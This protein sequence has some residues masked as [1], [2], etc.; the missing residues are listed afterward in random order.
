MTYDIQ[1]QFFLLQFWS[2]HKELHLLPDHVNI[3]MS[4]PKSI[5]P[6]H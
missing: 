6:N 4:Y 3:F 2:L 5:L 1:M